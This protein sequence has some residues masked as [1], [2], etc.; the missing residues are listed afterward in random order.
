MEFDI[1]EWRHYY[2][3]SMEFDIVDR[4][5]AVDGVRHCWQATKM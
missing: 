4:I 3:A 1:V 5:A 2:D